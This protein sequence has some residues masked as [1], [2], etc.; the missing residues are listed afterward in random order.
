MLANTKGETDVTV[1]IEGPDGD[2]SLTHGFF[3][4]IGSPVNG[5][6][7][8]PDGSFDM[9]Y[10]RPELA[11]TVLGFSGT[12]ARLQAWISTPKGP[13]VVL[14]HSFEEPIAVLADETIRVVGPAF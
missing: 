14:T 2:T 7:L 5:V 3:K 12:I 8:D 10:E 9:E 13:R 6:E 1:K 4:S 11:L